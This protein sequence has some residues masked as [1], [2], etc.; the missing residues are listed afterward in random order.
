RLP[1]VSIRER[2]PARHL[3]RPGPGGRAFDLPD[4]D[5]SGR[6][7]GRRSG[8]GAETRD[9]SGRGPG[10]GRLGTACALVFADAPTAPLASVLAASHALRRPLSER[11]AP[12]GARRVGRDPGLTCTSNAFI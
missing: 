10:L 12:A 11:S 1:G 2:R 9:P 4:E 3:A 6:R 5:R 7:S 8:P